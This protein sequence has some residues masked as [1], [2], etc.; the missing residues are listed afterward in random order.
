LEH[1]NEMLNSELLGQSRILLQK[2]L[3]L[4]RY[5]LLCH[6]SFP[7]GN[8]LLELLLDLSL[9]LQQSHLCT[10][11]K[12]KLTV[13]AI[14]AF[15]VDCVCRKFHFTQNLLQIFYVNFTTAN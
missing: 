8:N 4:R 12:S 1:F 2:D 14:D 15:S 11:F 7:L 13:L 6:F 3:L 9:L 10:L 5:L